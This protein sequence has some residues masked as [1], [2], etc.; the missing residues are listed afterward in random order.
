M[1]GPIAARCVTCN[2]EF[3]EEQ[4]EGAEACPTCGAKGIP[5]DPANDVTIK[6]NWH[7]L[8]ILTVWADNWAQERC[9]EDGQRSLAAILRRLQAQHP[10]RTALT[11]AGEIQ[12][13]ATALGTK[14]EMHGPEGRKVIEPEDKH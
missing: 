5:V 4:I 8:R 13:M 12:E 1:S 10:D 3:T 11:L 9:D 14:V 2:A 6:I 7:E